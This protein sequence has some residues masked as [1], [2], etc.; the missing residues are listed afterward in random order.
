VSRTD[1]VLTVRY[2]SARAAGGPRGIGRFVRYVQYRD[3]HPDSEEVHDLDGLI[4]YVHH[5]DRTSPR[6]QLFDAAGPA[7]DE[8][9]RD[10]VHYVARSTRELHRA[11]GPRSTTSERAVYRFILSPRDAGGLDLKRL[12]RAAM[13]QLAADG[14]RGGFPPWI[15]GEHRNTAHPHV[16]VILAA[17]REQASGDFRTL[18][19]TKPRLA[20]MKQALRLE[21]TRQQ[22][23]R[24]TLSVPSRRTGR[25]ELSLL[26]TVAWT[27]LAHKRF[28]V[29]IRHDATARVARLVARA[30]RRHREEAERLARMRR[31][32][33]D[34]DEDRSR[35]RRL[36]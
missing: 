36:R 12:T 6:G 17:R 29:Q 25:P 35:T 1:V 7:G 32:L 5:R 14:G 27:P 10:F 3:A 33:W 16:H 15:A 26:E 11:A 31:N 21:M 4:R 19:I 34:S 24:L 23:H 9:R 2:A 13:S 20:R 28:R 8:Q 30:A 18:V 22:D